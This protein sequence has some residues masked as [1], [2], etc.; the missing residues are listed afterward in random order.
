MT[1]RPT[2]S[3]YHPPRRSSGLDIP[4]WL[5]I[6]TLAARGPRWRLADDAPLSIAEARRLVAQGTL[7]MAQRRDGVSTVL[8]IKTPHL[9][10]DSVMRHKAP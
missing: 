3:V 5:P 1:A 10:G 7:L 8:V 9:Q 2:Y 6:A 4:Q